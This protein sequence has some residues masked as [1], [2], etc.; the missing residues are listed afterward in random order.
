MGSMSFGA[1]TL[2]AKKYNCEIVDPKP[3]VI[4]TVKDAFE[5]YSQ[6]DL[7]LPALGYSAEQLS[8]MEQIIDAIDCDVV[9]SGT[10]IDITRVL[11]VNKPLVR[12]RYELAEISGTPL[13]DAVKAAVQ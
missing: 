11:K 9:L 6:L 12:V 7:A 2:A 4:G 10:P 1:A 5:K 3:H 8:E 13:S